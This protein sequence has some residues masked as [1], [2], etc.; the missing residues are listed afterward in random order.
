M[1]EYLYIFAALVLISAV[2]MG[3]QLK[4]GHSKD[5]IRGDRINGFLNAAMELTLIII[6]V[7]FIV[8]LFTG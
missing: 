4:R 5:Q 3:L 2:R 6:A 7:S 8:N 1:Q